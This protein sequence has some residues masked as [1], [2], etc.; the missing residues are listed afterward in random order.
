MG[1][2][3]QSSDASVAPAPPR[4]G[5][6]V[7]ARSKNLSRILTLIHGRGPLPRA[8]LTR[9]TKLNRSTTAAIVGEL[10]ELGLVHEVEPH[11]ARGVGRPSPTVHSAPEVA[12]LAVI[13]EVDEVVVAIVGFDGTV[14]RTVRLATDNALTAD[15]MIRVISALIDGMRGELDVRFRIVGIGVSIPGVVRTSDGFVRYAPHLGWIDDEFAVPLRASTGYEVWAA[16]D[17]DLGARA[18]QMHGS[19]TMSRN[20]IYLNGGASG[21][22]A[23][24]ITGGRLLTGANGYAGE[25]GHMFVADNGIRCHCG[26]TGCLETE[27]SQR[28]LLAAAGLERDGG[29]RLGDALRGPRSAELTGETDRQL[30]ALSTGLRNIV[31]AVN[32]DT[33]VLGGF[34]AQLLEHDRDRLSH[35]FRSQTM[36]PLAGDVRVVPARLGNEVLLRGAAE[37]AFQELLSDP[38]AH[39]PRT[40]QGSAQI[41]ATA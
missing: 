3:E 33:I 24:I 1:A 15:Q 16:N 17:A 13:A 26:A 14:H 34:L 36:T 23:G 22:G 5:G 29:G 35:L 38:A 28:S 11:A 21:I 2:H 12:A 20:M 18:E 27:V 6:I 25:V 40:T 7:S 30:K 19:G 31:H 41:E 4:G 8:E 37:M 9:L 32:P 10:G 39:A